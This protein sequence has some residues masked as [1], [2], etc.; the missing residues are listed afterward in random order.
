MDGGVILG[1]LVALLALWA[2]LI[3]VL[4]LET[5]SAPAVTGRS[6]WR[7]SEHDRDPIVRSG[8]RIRSHP[9]LKI[10]RARPFATQ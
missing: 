7:C 5:S 1:L 10:E 8:D 3:V 9:H 2:T 6:S 4:W